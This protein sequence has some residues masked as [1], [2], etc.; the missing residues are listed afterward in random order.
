M[1]DELLRGFVPI[2]YAYRD[3]FRFQLIERVIKN[4]PEIFPRSPST[5]AITRNMANHVRPIPISVGDSS[6]D[7]VSRLPADPDVGAE[8]SELIC[9]PRYPLNNLF[10]EDDQKIPPVSMTT[11]VFNHCNSIPNEDPARFTAPN[12]PTPAAPCHALEKL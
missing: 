8:L 10:A 7:L 4:R 6:N 1:P 5:A 9:S 11:S 2:S 12:S 3:S